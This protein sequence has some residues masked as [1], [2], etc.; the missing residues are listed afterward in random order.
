VEY[1]NTSVYPI[2]NNTTYGTALKSRKKILNNPRKQYI[3][4]VK[5]SLGIGIHLL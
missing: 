4:T 2:I 3:T 5:D 1:D